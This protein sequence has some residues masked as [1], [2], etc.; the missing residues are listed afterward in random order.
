MK[1]IVIGTGFGARVVAPIYEA[2]GI[3][4]DIVSPHDGAAVRE[5]CARDV[6][7]VSVHSPPF[8]HH[9][10]V[11]IALDHKHAVLCDK[12][13]GRNATEARAMR[14]R[15]KAL[16]VLHFTNFEFRQQPARVTLKALLDQGRIGAIQHI[17]WTV[18]GCG[19]RGQTHRWLFEAE[20]SGGWLGAYGSHAIDT[21]RYLTGSEV[22][23]CSGTARTEIRSRPDKQGVMQPSTAEDAFSSWMKMGN[24]C[25]VGFD[26]AYS[27]PLALPSG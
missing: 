23:T 4:C 9:E 20:R 10:H 2:L 17:S 6:D 7:L 18:I 3:A 26:T 27:A 12:P 22:A 15:A 8:L 11:M 13:F 5:A 14:D 16:G 21:L 24:G 19:L 1:A 25:T